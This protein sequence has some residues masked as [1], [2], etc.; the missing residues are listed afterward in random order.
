M[1][2]LW[3]LLIVFVVL[4]LGCEENSTST[5]E[6]SIEPAMIQI[7]AGT[8]EMGCCGEDSNLNEQPV[9]SVSVSSFFMSKYEVTQKEFRQ[10]MGY[11]PAGGYGNGDNYPVF[12]VSWEEAMAYCNNRSNA[13][14]LEPCFNLAD[15]TCNFEA[16]GYRLP[17]EAEWE[18]AARGAGCDLTL[19]YAGADDIDDVAWYRLNSGNQTHKVGQ[20]LPNS[21]GLYDLSGNVWEWCWDWY[22]DEYYAESP[23]PDPT[24]PDIGFF[25]VV[26]GGSWYNEM[27]FC[28]CTF[29][30]VSESFGSNYIGLR[31]V[32]N[33]E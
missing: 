20:K 19:N 10:V 14:G 21:L 27:N 4:M 31:V 5:N 28:C 1:K 9:H 2:K 15:S 11:A 32:R 24:G 12:G 7:P 8:F 18:Y 33:A 29:R 30:S 25:R 23:S 6:V 26:R 22:S 16:N 13:E 3:L 17:T